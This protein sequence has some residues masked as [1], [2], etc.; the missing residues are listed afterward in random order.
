[1]GCRFS[2]DLI[3]RIKE[4]FLAAVRA[5]SRPVICQVLMAGKHFFFFA[6][7]LANGKHTMLKMFVY[8]PRLTCIFFWSFAG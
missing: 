3:M 1:M 8:H 4:H 7:I 6:S 2:S 5:I